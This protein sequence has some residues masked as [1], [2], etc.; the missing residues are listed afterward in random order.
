VLAVVV[1][2]AV[3]S[4]TSWSAVTRRRIAPA[5]LVRATTWIDVGFGAAITAATGGASSPFFAFVIFAVI[6]AG[7]ASE[8]RRTIAVTAV[9]VAL[10]ASFVVISTPADWKFYVM[11]PVYLAVTGWLIAAAAQHRSRRCRGGASV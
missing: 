3:Y 2:H 9:S 10:F 5:A 4:V 1:A 7:L 8:F 6:S 11:R